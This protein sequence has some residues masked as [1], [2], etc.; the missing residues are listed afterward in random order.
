MQ[1]CLSS[2][3]HRNSTGTLNRSSPA[4]DLASNVS[5]VVTHTHRKSARSAL[6]SSSSSTLLQR[7][8][9]ALG[10]G[11]PQHG[12]RHDRIAVH[13]AVENLDA[14]PAVATGPKLSDLPLQAIIN[15][16]VSFR[17]GLAECVRRNLILVH[18]TYGNLSPSLWS[19]PICPHSWLVQTDHHILVTIYM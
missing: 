14:E 4:H 3:S 7:S 12:S 5:N 19:S 10:P 6:F 9:C 8:A 18:A 1:K 16:Q 13:A 17:H 2:C 11:L 15:P